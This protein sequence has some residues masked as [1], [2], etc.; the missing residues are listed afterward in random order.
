MMSFLFNPIFPS[1]RAALLPFAAKQSQGII[2]RLLRREEH[3]PR[4]DGGMMMEFVV[5]NV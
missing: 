4:N 1:L 3:P 5:K 2:I